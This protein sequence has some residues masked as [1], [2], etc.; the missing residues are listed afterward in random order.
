MRIIIDQGDTTAL[1]GRLAMRTNG[2]YR[3]KVADRVDSFESNS[4]TSADFLGG[5]RLAACKFLW[6]ARPT[7]SQ[8][9]FGG[10]VVLKN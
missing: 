5:F 8:H 10:F 2:I 1:Q 4:N 7:D 3:F 6:H 9:I